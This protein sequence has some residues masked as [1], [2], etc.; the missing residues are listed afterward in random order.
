LISLVLFNVSFDYVGKKVI[1]M[2][3]NK[4]RE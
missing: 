1:N 4:T 2:Y 3:K